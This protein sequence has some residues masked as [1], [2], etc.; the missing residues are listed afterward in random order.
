MNFFEFRERAGS[1]VEDATEDLAETL[2]GAAIE[3]HRILGPGL[4]ESVYRNALKHE[5]QLQ[6]IACAMEAVVPVV[7]KGQLVG[8]GHLDL[9]IE[10]AHRGIESRRIPRRC[11]P[12]TSARISKSDKAPTGF[13]D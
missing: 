3:V 1:G 7:Y 13:V 8:E 10:S 9:L 11:A 6:G 12:R 4:P 2:I 5:L